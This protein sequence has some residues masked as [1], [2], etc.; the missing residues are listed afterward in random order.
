[1]ESKVKLVGHPVHPMLIVF[2]LGLLATSFIFDIVRL[3][4]QNDAFGQVSFWMILAGII[5]GLAAAVFGLID[6]IGVPGGTRAKTLGLYHGG[7]N[8]IVVVLFFISWLVRLGQPAFVADTAAFVLSLAGVLIALATGWL[9][10]ELVD[11]LG[12]GV[13]PGANVNA[14]SS[15]GGLPASAVPTPSMAPPESAPAPPEDT[16]GR[17]A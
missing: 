12:V 15:L 7:G 4:T 9:G 1:M 11:R 16:T 13:D 17:A 10:G 6:W 5:G 8:V 3:I 14:P 2:P